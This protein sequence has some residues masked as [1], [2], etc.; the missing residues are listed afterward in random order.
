MAQVWRNGPQDGGELLVLLAL[1][2]FAD[3]DGYC[4]PSMSSIAKK[5]RM[6]ER[7]ARKIARRLEDAGHLSCEVGGGR[8]GVNRYRVHVKNPEPETRNTVPPEPETRNTDAETRNQSAETRNGGSA[9][10]SRTI[11]EPSDTK[12]AQDYLTRV[13]SPMVADDFI[14]HRKAIKKPL[15]P[16]AAKLIAKQL[17]GHFDPDEVACVSIRNGW[18]GVFPDN[19]KPSVAKPDLWAMMQSIG[20]DM[21]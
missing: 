10:P 15:T 3:D 7:G 12:K 1:A 18:A 13:L 8:N 21:R 2:D 20:E 14:A 16:Q 9:K 5:A 11:K 4:W 17:E 6:T 19:V